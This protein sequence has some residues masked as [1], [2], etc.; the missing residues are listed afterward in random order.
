[1]RQKYMPAS[2]TQSQTTLTRGM[3]AANAP[4]GAMPQPRPPPVAAYGAGDVEVSAYQIIQGKNQIA[5][6]IRSDQG[7][8]R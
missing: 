7:G 6:L 4:A 5:I 1:M 8:G 2:T 3:Q